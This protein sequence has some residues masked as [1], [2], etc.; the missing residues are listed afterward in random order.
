MECR[1][2]TARVNKEDVERRATSLLARTEA[3]SSETMS[4]KHQMQIA[5][6]S[7]ILSKEFSFITTAARTVQ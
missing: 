6:S 7:S 5:K 2:D 4:T 3:V 1:S